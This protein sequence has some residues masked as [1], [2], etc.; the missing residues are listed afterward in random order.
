MRIALEQI[1][2]IT[3]GRLDKMP[4]GN[5]GQDHDPRAR[6]GERPARRRH[7]RSS[8]RVFEGQ[9]WK[10]LKTVNAN[11][12]GRTDEPLLEGDKLRAGT[13]SCSFHVGE[14]FGRKNFLDVVPVRF[15]IADASAHYMSRC[16]ATPWG[17]TTYRGS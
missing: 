11:K 6:H 13:Y 14:Y 7:E 5:D 1:G 2:H 12:D 15:G 3:R 8:S 4:R 10:P 17:Y 16:S 9:G